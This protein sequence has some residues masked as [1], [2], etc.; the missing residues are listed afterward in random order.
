MTQSFSWYYFCLNVGALVGE[1]GMPILRQ[2]FGFITAFFSV[3]GDSVT[4]TYHF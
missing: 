3:A 1:A 2:S 4:L